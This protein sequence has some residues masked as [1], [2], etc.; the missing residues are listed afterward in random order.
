MQTTQSIWSC[1]L[2]KQEDL[3]KN[4]IQNQYSKNVFQK[5]TSCVRKG[6]VSTNN[7]DW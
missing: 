6:P 5:V 3:H 7:R 1:K 4:Q 2:M